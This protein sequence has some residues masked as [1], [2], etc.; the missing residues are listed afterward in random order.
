MVRL[1]FDESAAA[2]PDGTA[3]ANRFQRAVSGQKPNRP[4]PRRLP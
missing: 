3:T 4:S 2:S 1:T